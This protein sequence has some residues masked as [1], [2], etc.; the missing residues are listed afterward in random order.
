MSLVQAAVPPVPRG[1]GE[2]WRRLI[3]PS[4]GDPAGTGGPFLPAGAILLI[5][6]GALVLACD[7]YTGCHVARLYQAQPRGG[8]E[9]VRTWTLKAPPG[10]MVAARIAE[11]LAP[12]AAWHRYEHPDPDGYIGTCRYCR[13]P[14]AATAGRAWQDGRTGEPK[15][16]HGKGLCLV[17]L[18]LPE[19]EEPSLYG[20]ACVTCGGWVEPETGAVILAPAPEPGSKARY[21]PVHTGRCPEPRPPG[22]VNAHDGWCADC[23]GPLRPGEGCWVRG[24]GEPRPLLRHQGICPR[25]GPYH[26][27]WMT[28]IHPDMAPRGG[29]VIRAAVSLGAGGPLLT[30]G[31]PGYL[32][33][34]DGMTEIAGVVIGCGSGMARVRSATAEEAAALDGGP[35]PGAAPDGYR[36]AWRAERIGDAEPWLP[37]LAGFDALYGYDR[38]FLRAKLDYRD[39]NRKLTRGVH[40]TWTLRLN[41]VYEAH[42]NIARGRTERLFLRATPE[43]DA[44]EISREEAEAWLRR[45]AS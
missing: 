14:V 20:G 19:R 8:L 3:R 12:D 26:P 6:A 4:A 15:A 24:D 1:A 27:S 11:R 35:H 29:D 16:A 40:Y 32:E 43:G 21:Q 41:E 44:Q 37:R 17:P 36:A 23:S 5:S 18:P 45:R 9:I 31:I 25:R 2:S 34:A 7:R 28:R 33:L 42:R 30:A 39:A 22:P 10:R 38:K 13:H